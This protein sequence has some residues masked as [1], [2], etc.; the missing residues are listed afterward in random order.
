EISDRVC[1]LHGGTIAEVGTPAELF[2]A[3]RDERTKQFL[4][5]VR[6]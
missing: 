5:R 2:S 6:M 1:F 3:P 4:R